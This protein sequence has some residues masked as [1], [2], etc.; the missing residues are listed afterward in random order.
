MAQLLASI[1]DPIAL[2]GAIA[3]SATVVSVVTF[4]V[5]DIFIDGDSNEDPHADIEWGSANY[6][7]PPPAPRFNRRDDEE[8]VSVI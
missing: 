6:D 3:G 4:G 7:E 2:A 5:Y 1:E 8:C